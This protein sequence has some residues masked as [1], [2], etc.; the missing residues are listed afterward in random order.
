MIYRNTISQHIVFQYGEFFVNPR[1]FA[2]LAVAA[3]SLSACIIIDADEVDRDNFHVVTQFGLPHL[4][5]VSINQANVTVEIPGSC[6]TRQNVEAAVDRDGRRDYQIGIDYSD[7][8]NCNEDSAGV[9]PLSWTFEELGIPL[10]S[11][12]RVLNKVSR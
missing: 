9:A 5:S 11:T 10:D 7:R 6:A 8:D 1:T 4:Q 3:A 12:V 2:F